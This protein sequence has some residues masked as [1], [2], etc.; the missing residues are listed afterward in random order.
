M[1]FTTTLGVKIWFSQLKD[2]GVDLR[3]ITNLRIAAD[4]LAV[5]RYLEQYGVF[6]DGVGPGVWS[7]STVNQWFVEA[8]LGVEGQSLPNASQ[9][10]HLY[11]LDLTRSWLDVARM[12]LEDGVDAVWST[13]RPSWWTSLFSLDDIWNDE[14][15]RPFESAGAE[16]D[17]DV[18]EQM[19]KTF[20]RGDVEDA[21][22][23]RG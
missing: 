23:V 17:W 21:A 7:D 14:A 5:A 19:Q 1:Y 15:V 12:W 22:V 3:Q 18:C 13:S 8:S 20:W 6:A 10:V 9:A 2:L 11:S 4:S 16:D